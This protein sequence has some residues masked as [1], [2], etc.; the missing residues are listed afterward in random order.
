MENE[1]KEIVTQVAEWTPELI[2]L[3]IKE[4][5][6]PI[7]VLILGWTF[8]SNI[9]SALKGLFKGRKITEVS[10]GT[11]GVIAKFAQ[12]TAE[13]KKEVIAQGEVLPEGQDYESLINRQ[14]ELNTEYSLVLLNN[15]NKHLNALGINDQQK[16]DLL[17]KELSL[18]QQA[19]N[20]QHVNKVMFKSQFDLFNIM[21]VDGTSIPESDIKQYFNNLPT[22]NLLVGWDYLKFLSYPQTIGLIELH[23][24]EYRLTKNGISYVNFMK[25]NL[26][27]IEDL[28][29]I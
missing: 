11:K 15:I 14:N 1:V 21:P 18:S 20:L 5:A 22:K 29:K 27:L 12:E 10:A 6:W 2:V 4:I 7:T 16:I 28:I 8:R 19:L 24:D 26:S 3:L 9:S 13:S 23:N 25:K 17:T